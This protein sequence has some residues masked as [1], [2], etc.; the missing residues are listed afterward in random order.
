MPH[1]SLA[2]DYFETLKDKGDA[3]FSYLSSLPAQSS[4]VS[5]EEWLDFK[6]GR[7]IDDE[8]VKKLW[9]ENLSAFGN[10]QGGV[11]VW[12]LD[13]RKNPERVDRVSKISFVRNPEAFKSRLM[14]LHHQATEPPVQ[15]VEVLAVPDPKDS[16]QGFVV[17]FIPE[18]P[19]KPVRSEH[20]HNGKQYYIRAGDDSIVPSLSLLRLLFMPGGGAVLS[21]GVVI[22]HGRISGPYPPGM[23]TPVFRFVIKNQSLVSAKGV[24]LTIASVTQVNI[25]FATHP[26]R[27]NNLGDYRYRFECTQA[28]HPGEELDVGVLQDEQHPILADG[29]VGGLADGRHIQFHVKLFGENMP[30]RNGNILFSHDKLKSMGLHALLLEDLK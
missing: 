18:S 3:L 10:T 21:I 26:F 20:N 12:G 27:F 30:P 16:T 8:K 24:I 13:C 25:L 1:P 19:V 23:L 2:S 14:E 17:C 9:S 11:L 4:G 29:T 15:G 28:I 5:E 22:S 7:H 6:D